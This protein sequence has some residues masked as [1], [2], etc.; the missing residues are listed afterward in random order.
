VAYELHL[1]PRSSHQRIARQVRDLRAQPILDVGA[2]SGQLGWL[3]ADA[4]LVIDA[5]EPD[6]AAAD[7]AAPYYRS[8]QR[9][10]V[11]GAALPASTYRVVVCADVL[12]HLHDPA[13]QLKRLLASATA[14]ATVIVSVPNVAHLAARLLLLAGKFPRHSRGI[15]D[16]T[17]RHFYTR[18]TLLELLDAAGLA[19]TTIEVT[20]VPL[21]DFWPSGWPSHLKEAVMRLQSLAG[22]IS[23][24]LFG[25][26]WVATATRAHGLTPLHPVSS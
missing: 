1:D 18:D 4:R 23:P 24:R 16:R 15:F 25:Y 11:E 9:T 8:V 21:E 7:A 6:H 10:T 22:R 2:A 20:P 19:V 17:H 13:E 14:D 26:Q 5:I 12:E 3:L